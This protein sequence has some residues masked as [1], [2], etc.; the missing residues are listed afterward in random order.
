MDSC[1]I[2]FNNIS[3]GLEAMD[4]LR[5]T[6]ADPTTHQMMSFQYIPYW[7]RAF[8]RYRWPATIALQGQFWPGS[9]RGNISCEKVFAI[10]TEREGWLLPP[11]LPGLFGCSCIEGVAECNNNTSLSARKLRP[12]P[13]ML[14]HSIRC[15]GPEREREL[16]FRVERKRR[17]KIMRTD[18]AGPAWKSNKATRGIETTLL[19]PKNAFI[20]NSLTTT[21]LG[22][23]NCIVKVAEK[24][25]K[26]VAS[27]VSH[28]C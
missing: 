26:N 12:F 19:R 8:E 5:F 23:F 6:I 28:Q 16:V 27:G 7:A 21:Q 4:E 1:D 11:T 2:I 17:M 15:S 18:Q 10:N 3:K 22:L 9:D 13:P 24:G 20:I 14:L 25:E